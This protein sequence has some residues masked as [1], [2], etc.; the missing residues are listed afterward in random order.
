MTQ[1]KFQTLR[2]IGLFRD[3]HQLLYQIKVRTSKMCVVINLTEYG[4]WFMI[5][6]NLLMDINASYDRYEM[7]RFK[8]YLDQGFLN[9]IL[10]IYLGVLKLFPG[11]LIWNSIFLVKFSGNIGRN[12]FLTRIASQKI[13]R[14]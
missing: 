1:N 7:R 11:N 12:S 13:F 5:R 9:Y 4:G 3:D 10:L 8:F 14:S 6:T 2:K